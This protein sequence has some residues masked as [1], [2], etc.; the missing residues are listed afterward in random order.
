MNIYELHAGS[1][2]HKP[3][4][5]QPDGSDGWYDYEELARELIPWLLEHHFTHVEL[6]PLAEHPFDGSW[7]YQTTGYFAV[8]S[9]YAPRP[10]L[11]LRQRLPPDG[12]RRHHGLCPRPLCS[13]RRRAGQL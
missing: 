2:K 9:R 3:N 8:T 1:W 11:L 12:H 7:G 10:S 4:S 13:Q 6:L 5:T